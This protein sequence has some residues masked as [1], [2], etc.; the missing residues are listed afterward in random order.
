MPRIIV[1]TIDGEVVETIDHDDIG[2][3]DKSIDLNDLAASIRVAVSRA[4]RIEKERW[5]PK[6]K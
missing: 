1:T 5:S 4:R 6:E 2:N 3:L